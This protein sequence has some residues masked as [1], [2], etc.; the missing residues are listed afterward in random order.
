MNVTKDSKLKINIKRFNTCNGSIETC[1]YFKQLVL[2]YQLYGVHDES[3]STQQN[4]TTIG[5]LINN[6]HHLI[7]NHD[8]NDKE[9]QYI[10]NAL[11]NACKINTCKPFQRYYCRQ[12]DDYP[13][14]FANT[15]RKLALLRQIL[16]QIHCHYTHQYDVGL[17]FMPETIDNN[18]EKHEYTTQHHQYNIHKPQKFASHFNTTHTSTNNNEKIDEYTKIYSYSYSFNYWDNC[19]DCTDISYNDLTYDD[20]Y[21]ANKYKFSNLKEE[22]FNHEKDFRLGT[23]NVWF[24]YSHEYIQTPAAKMLSAKSAKYW[25]ATSHFPDHPSKYGYDENKC[26]TQQNMTTIVIYCNEDIFQANFSETYRAITDNEPLVNIKDRHSAYYW[27]AKLLRETVSVY[28]I[29]YKDG[30]ES[31][32]YHGATGEML[33]DGFQCQIFGVLSTSSRLHVA[34]RFSSNPGLVLEMV[35]DPYLK[36]FD[37]AP[38]S[39]FTYEWELLFVGGCA[40]M[41][42]INIR[43]IG[44]KL[45]VNNVIEMMEI[46]IDDELKDEYYFQALRIIDTMTNGVYYDND[47]TNVLRMKDKETGKWIV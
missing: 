32:M 8:K 34:Q 21:V 37:C 14:I 42:I 3:L 38:W 9:F 10:Y 17:R 36:Y 22:L 39:L 15:D 16:D 7:E 24:G 44:N 6:F 45:N 20:L 26:I 2:Q 40:M 13:N 12:F 1:G 4:G 31:R 35:P 29:Q 28:G 46:D 18:D 47:P 30:K 43:N 23:I 27:F 19:K 5:D 33:L 25:T 41:N 11:G